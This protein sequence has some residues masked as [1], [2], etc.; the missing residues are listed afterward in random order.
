M[1]F[2]DLFR[3]AYSNW[4]QARAKKFT[5]RK[6]SRSASRYYRHRAVQTDYIPAPRKGWHYEHG[7]LVRNT[8]AAV[9]LLALPGCASQQIDHVLANLDK[10][11]TR[12]YSGSIGGIGIVAQA[13]FEIDC[14]ASGTTITTTTTFVPANPNTPT[15][16][17]NGQ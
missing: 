12:H 15:G 14:K 6:V 5:Q 9:V 8:I 7:D 16:Q 1:N 13:T 4:F 11:C 2:F 17:P 3:T 10:D